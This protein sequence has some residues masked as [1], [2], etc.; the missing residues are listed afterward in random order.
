[1]I[2]IK[3]QCEQYVDGKWALM[4]HGDIHYNPRGIVHATRVVGDQPFLALSIFTPP[5]P[6]G[7][8]RVFLNSEITTAKEGAIV[9]NW[10]LLDT[11]YKKGDIF[12][13][14]AWHAS[15]PIESGKT[16]RSEPAMGTLRGQLM[17][18][19]MPALP[20]HYHGSADE[21]IYTYKGAGEIYINGEWT[22]LTPGM[23]HFCPRGM[24]HGIRPAGSEYK[25]FAFFA[26]PQANNSDRIFVDL[27]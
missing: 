2:P 10:S 6:G 7:N 8:D 15:H 1:V 18:A 19:Q 14:D 22:K 12:N 3:G 4:K 27:K 11:Q 5:P 26:P 17:I 21:I 13:M 9:G 16:M 25:I 23:I 24:I 20:V